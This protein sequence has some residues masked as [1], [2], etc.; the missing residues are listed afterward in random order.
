M[1]PLSA[2]GVPDVVVTSLFPGSDSVSAPME[3]GFFG[4]GMAIT[5]TSFST[6]DDAV[7]DVLDGGELEDLFM[8]RSMTES[9]GYD[10]WWLSSTERDEDEVRDS[11]LSCDSCRW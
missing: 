4:G 9:Q 10:L 7:L 5:P 1:P 3:A 8:L 2:V 6:L 11:T